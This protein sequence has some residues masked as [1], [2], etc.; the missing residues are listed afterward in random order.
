MKPTDRRISALESVLMP[1]RRDSNRP[2]TP[3]D[4]DLFVIA[5]A[6]EGTPED[7]ITYGV[8]WSYCTDRDGPYEGTRVTNAELLELQKKFRVFTMIVRL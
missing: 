7:E 2:I 3:A 1:K 8:Q 4:C 6:E 5:E